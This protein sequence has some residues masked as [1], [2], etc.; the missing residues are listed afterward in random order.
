MAEGSLFTELVRAVLSASESNE[1]A[2]AVTEWDVVA[3]EEDPTSKGTCT[4]GKVGLAKLFTIYN[5]L[6]ENKLYPIGSHCVKQ[7]EIEELDQEVSLLE[8]LLSLRKAFSEN[9]VEL[10]SEFFSRS[11]LKYFQSQGVFTVDQWNKNG[12]ADLEFLLKMFNKRNKQSISEG[13][14]RKIS[15][16]LSR[17]IR[18]YIFNDERLSS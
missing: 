17:K 6:N 1:W 8:R 12:N 16:L 3:L 2:V 15:L 4:C 10:T 9:R 18:P 7:F 5:R 13:Q 11:L 14:R